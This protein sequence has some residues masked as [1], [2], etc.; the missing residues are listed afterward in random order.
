[1]GSGG[2]GF[3]A[4][5]GATGASDELP[6]IEDEDSRFGIGTST[7]A[8]GDEDEDDSD[9]PAGMPVAGAAIEDPSSLRFDAASP[10]SL[11]SFGAGG[12][13]SEAL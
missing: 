3:G 6:E 12:A 11:G 1:M 5:G 10:A 8:P 9:S 7:V 13:D 2:S 4:V